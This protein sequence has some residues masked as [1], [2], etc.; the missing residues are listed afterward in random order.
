MQFIIIPI[1][2]LKEID[3]NWE[4]CRKSNDGTKAIIHKEIYDALVPEQPKPMMMMAMSAETQE[5][6][7]REYPYPLISGEEINSLEEFKSKE[8][9]LK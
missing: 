7:E 4:H 9:D 8:E 6:T 5:Q 2:E 1:E 3:A